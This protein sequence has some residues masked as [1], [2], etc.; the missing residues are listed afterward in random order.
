MI[1]SNK[2]TFTIHAYENICHVMLLHKYRHIM[3][4][5]AKPGP[6]TVSPVNPS[7]TKPV[8]V[9]VMDCRKLY[10]KRKLVSVFAKSIMLT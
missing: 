5:I 4:K 10:F 3:L 9:F 1:L 7:F 2:F 8:S 6:E